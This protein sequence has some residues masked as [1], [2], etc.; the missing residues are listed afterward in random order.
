[1][2]L[3]DQGIKLRMVLL[4]AWSC[5]NSDVEACDVFTPDATE[6]TFAA[7]SCSTFMPARH[8]NTP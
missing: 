3:R 7:C 5:Q 2:Q 8:A 4:P 1:M 6:S